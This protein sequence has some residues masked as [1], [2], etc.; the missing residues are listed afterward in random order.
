M[1][2]LAVLMVAGLIA[3]G[4][5]EALAGGTTEDRVFFSES[6]GT[7]Q[8]FRIYLPEGYDPEGET[9]YP[10]VYFLHGST[11]GYPIY[12]SIFGFKA[13]L[14]E[15]IEDQVIQ[16]IIFVTPNGLVGPFSGSR[17]A[18]S[19]LY[20]NFE[21]YVVYDLVEFV[22]SNYRTLASRSYRCIVGLSM[23]ANGAMR[24][25]LKHPDTYRAV[26][27]HS[28]LIDHDVSIASQRDNLLAEYDGPPY[29]WNPDAGRF[30]MVTFGRAGAYSTNFDNPPY[31]VDFP[32]D[33]WGEI[34]P[35]VMDRWHI[36]SPP[37]LARVLGPDCS[38]GIYFDC[39]T[40]DD[41]VAYP[42][43]LA[44]ADSL[45]ALEL[46][47]EF[48][49]FEGMHYDRFTERLPIALEFLSDAMETPTCVALDIK[50]GKCPN[51]IQLDED[52]DERL[53]VAL[54]GTMGI[55]VSLIDTES[56]LLE[57]FVEPVKIGYKDVATPILSE[58][59][60]ECTSERADGHED[61]RLKFEMEDVLAALGH[62]ED[63]DVREITV[64]GT[65]L[66]GAPFVATDCVVIRGDDADDED[67]DEDDDRAVPD[68]GIATFLSSGILGRGFSA[69]S[70]HI[71]FALHEPTHVRIAIYDATGRVVRHLVDAPTPA[72]VHTLTWD[73][74]DDAGRVA[75]SGVYYARLDAEGQP[76]GRDTQ[77]LVI[78]R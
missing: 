10:V 17:W 43:N 22:D 54:L 19:P 76:V 3:C 12:W 38:L 73:G 69:G 6:V 65:F 39:G 57:G 59:F 20:G 45:D 62:V 61:L 21:D 66:D 48:Q 55:D 9:E 72:G 51:H 14:D 71:S 29:A 27:A 60:C 26:G 47:Y 31:L 70:A 25:A 35:S 56:V 32:R 67:D 23:G 64:S 13:M 40:Y 74:S 41:W 11:Y 1:R 58:D 42:C 33:Q 37:Y 46:P 30:S 50:P 49:S 52:D 16:P 44:L 4:T 28:G 78:L 75:T 34:I 7:D 24:L 63:G 5:I 15:L 68:H 53:I 77:R 18:N 2:K 36:E 8:D